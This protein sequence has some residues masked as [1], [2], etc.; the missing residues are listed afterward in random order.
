MTRMTRYGKALVKWG[1]VFVSFVQFGSFGSSAV[2]GPVGRDR[3]RKSLTNLFRAYLTLG[4]AEHSLEDRERHRPGLLGDR[5]SP[6][7]D[8]D[9]G[10]APN[11]ESLS[12]LWRGV[13]VQLRDQRAAGHLRGE[14]VHEGRHHL[15]RAAPVG[16]EVDQH[17]KL[18]IVH[19]PAE[20]LVGEL[21]RAVE[22]DRTRALPALWP[23]SRSCGV[24]AI[25]GEAE[26]A[27]DGES[28]ARLLGRCR[29][30]HE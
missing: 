5:L 20:R 9:R 2:R 10:N 26:L 1:A 28:G 3:S 7:K 25:P 8:D 29:R 30:C 19:R 23:V 14:L 27:L 11:V 24:D 18:S 12:G 21:E 17:R 4:D 22:Q 15:A 13:G 16:V 6:A